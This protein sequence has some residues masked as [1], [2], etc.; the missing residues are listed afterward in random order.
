MKIYAVVI[1]II[2][3]LALILAGYLFW[4]M[5]AIQTNLNQAQEQQRQANDELTQVKTE[6]SQTKDEL[7]K[8]RELI[9]TG[10]TTAK[11]NS[12]ILKNSLET[13][14]VAGDLKIFT[15]SETE[16]QAITD[17]IQSLSDKMDKV[18]LEKAWS[19]FLKSQKI[20]DYFAFA[21]AAASNI[22]GKLQN[23]H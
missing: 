11:E 10:L 21:R 14:L 7:N 4:Q 19:D 3:V 20:T 23:I 2:A 8:V 15:I 1:T 6:L 13:F 12:D 22:N 16:A 18:G 5:T 17:K 9:D